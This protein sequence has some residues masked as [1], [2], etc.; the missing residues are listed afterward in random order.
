[1]WYPPQQCVA[2]AEEPASVRTLLPT[3]VELASALTDNI[4]QTDT[5]PCTQP[6]ADPRAI[7]ECRAPKSHTPH[8]VWTPVLPVPCPLPR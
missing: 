5:G 6:E 1:M 2:R 7:P 8:K 3:L 4:Q